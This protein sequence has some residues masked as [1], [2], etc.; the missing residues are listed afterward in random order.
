MYT[1]HWHRLCTYIYIH[2]YTCTYTYNY[3]AHFHQRAIHKY[4][5]QCINIIYYM[6]S[7]HTDIHSLHVHTLFTCMHAVMNLKHAHIYVECI[8]FNHTFIPFI[9]IKIHSSLMYGAPCWAEW[10]QGVWLSG[11]EGHSPAVS[12]WACDGPPPPTEGAWHLQNWYTIFSTWRIHWSYCN[13]S[14]TGSYWWIMHWD[15]LC[16]K[17]I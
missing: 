5:I 6:Y 10:T 13:D 16:N 14:T 2:R 4:I 7:R 8:C 15:S 9:S 1:H 12:L 3:T 11:L 17:Q